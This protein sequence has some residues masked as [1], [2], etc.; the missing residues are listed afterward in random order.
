M[1]IAPLAGPGGLYTVSILP[2]FLLGSERVG[3]QGAYFTDI[4]GAPAGTVDHGH[5]RYCIQRSLHDESRQP[6]RGGPWRVVPAAFAVWQAGDEC[7]FHWRHGGRS[8]FLFLAPEQ[9]ESVLG[10][11]PRR[12]APH[13]DCEPQPTRVL[14]LIFDALQADL[15]QGSPAGPLVGD[16]LIAALL[17]QLAGSSGRAV[18]PLGRPA[19]ARV[20]EFL[21]ARFAQPIRLEDLAAVAGVGVRQLSRAFR[22]ATGQ[23][24]YQYILRRRVEHAKGLI[25]RGVPLAEVAQQCGFID[26]SQLTRTFAQ[27]VG[28]TPG[29]YRARLRR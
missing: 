11:V 1:P 26:Q 12:L 14:E 20:V 15:A 6:L 2:R 3:W 24:P 4:D 7:R 9:V 28:I 10:S 19:R 22:A 5:Q 16:A 21:E 18:G 8:Q 25:A 29:G 13:G 27:R 17:A 23:S